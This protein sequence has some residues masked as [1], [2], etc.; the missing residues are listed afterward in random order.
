MNE[1]GKWLKS[2]A[3]GL[4]SKFRRNESRRN[5]KVSKKGHNGQ[6]KRSKTTGLS[7][8]KKNQR[9]ALPLYKGIVP[10]KLLCPVHFVKNIHSWA[11]THSSSCAAT[12]RQELLQELLFFSSS[13][14]PAQ[15]TQRD[16]ASL[17]LKQPANNAAGCCGASGKRRFTDRKL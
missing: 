11:S 13:K 4:K 15:T 5:N 6:K 3:R 10:R 12:F 16:A 7:S 8:S 1:R 14:Q 17:P 2:S 9:Y